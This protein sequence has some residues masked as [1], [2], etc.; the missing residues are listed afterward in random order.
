[1]LTWAMTSGQAW[2]L[3]IGAGVASFCVQTHIGYAPIAVPL[4]VG[5]TITLIV[6]TVR[7]H[8]DSVDARRRRYRAPIRA[9]VIAAAVL[10]VIWLP[11]V[12]QQIVDTPGNLSEVVQYFNNPK[13]P[14]HTFAEGYRAVSGQFELIPQW[15]TGHLD[16]S[17]F[18]GEPNL[19]Y[20]APLPLLLIPLGLALAAFWRWRYAEANRLGAVLLVALVVGVF[21]ISRIFGPAYAYR[22]RWTWF[23]GALAFIVVL[24]AAWTLISRQTRSSD[25][26]QR[27]LL[28]V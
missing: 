9:G 28:G 5:G 19:L 22:L 7:R 18:T 25:G 20:S 27:A 4:V 14:T 16:V 8:G 12:I 23:L 15:S 21:S 1:F 26:G 10:I 17:P 24:W 2:A 11:A 6:L 3:P 13:D